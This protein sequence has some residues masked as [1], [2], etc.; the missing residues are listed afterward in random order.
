MRFGPVP[1]SEAEGAVLAHSL[2]HPGGVIKKGR[3]LS[4]ADLARLAAAGIEEITVARRGAEDVAEDEAARRIA[5]LIAPPTGPT[6]LSAPFTGRANL[7]ADLAGV[8]EL[9]PER[10]D[11]LNR[12]DEA[13]TVATL[14]QYARAHPRQMLATVKI[15][16]YA[17]ADA[18]V[19][20]AEALLATGPILRLHPFTVAR[21]SLIL[22]Q[23]PGMSERVLDKGAKAVRDRLQALG[24]ALVT[25]R[26]V[27]HET[28]RIAEAMAA[29]EGDMILILTG[30]ATSDRADMGPAGLEAAGGRLLRFGMPV[31]PGNLLFLGDLGGRK[32]IGLP[33]CARS[34]K[35]NGADWVLERL[36]AGL[37]VGTA[38]IA[39]MG[40]GGLLKE[41]PSRPNPRTGGDAT[42]RR[43]VIAAVLLAAGRS[44]RMQG[45][46]KLLEPVGGEALLRRLAREALAS[47]AD[48][49]I[50]VLREDDPAREAALEGLDLSLCRNRQAAEGMGTSIAAAIRA[51]G[52]EVDGAL[53]LMA[54]MPEVTAADLDR[55]IAGFDPAEGRAIVRATTMSGAPGHPVLFGRR[56]FE[57]LAALEGDIG[58]R[59]V[60]REHADFIVEVALP[61]ECAVTDLDTQEDWAEWRR[62]A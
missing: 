33:G 41:I 18:A 62:K 13:I 26:V 31:D 34:P 23:V 57:P 28:A 44:R 32:V 12:I 39:A 54:D 6:T 52:E 29:A 8:V 38:Q 17:V 10:I 19:A 16:P 1:L 30:S 22:T 45:R 37:E 53:I 58:A 51:L 50:A 11:A 9:D 24:I 35:L 42:P 55:L 59:D 27:A 60:L 5:A 40:V 48:Q 21:A 4:A 46:D 61:G 7:Y 47:G 15:I 25:E 14:G 2:R 49:T 43:P 20:R 56:F 36:A 3:T